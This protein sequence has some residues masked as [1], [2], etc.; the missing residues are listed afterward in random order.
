MTGQD[1]VGNI[2][3]DHRIYILAT[4]MMFYLILSARKSLCFIAYNNVIG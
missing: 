3:G 2:V 1:L 4:I